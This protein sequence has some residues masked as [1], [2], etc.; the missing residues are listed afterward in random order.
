MLSLTDYN[1]KIASCRTKLTRWSRRTF[2]N[3]R[4]LIEKTKER[5]QVIAR[6]SPTHQLQLE[7]KALKSKIHALWKYEEIY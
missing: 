3:N 6:T 2:G 7:E 4:K 5:L 1:N